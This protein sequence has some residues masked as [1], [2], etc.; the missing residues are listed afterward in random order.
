MNNNQATP[1]DEQPEEARSIIAMPSQE[2]V[3]YSEYVKRAGLAGTPISAEDLVNTEFD[4]LRAKE[5]PSTFSTQ[6]HVWYCVVR[7]VGKD[8]LL[9]VSLGGQAVVEVLDAYS[10]SDESAPL[11]VTLRFKTGGKYSGYYYFE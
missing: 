3:K 4:I 7:P 11:R 2:P 9:S 10:H 6:D 1:F 8:E 5:Y